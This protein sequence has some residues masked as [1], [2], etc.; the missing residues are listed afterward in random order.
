METGA[1]DTTEA[2]V[3]TNPVNDESAISGVPTEYFKET[4]RVDT[5]T[6]VDGDGIP[7]FVQETRRIETRDIDGDG[8]P[9]I[10]RITTTTTVIRGEGDSVQ[11]EENMEFS[12]RQW[13]SEARDSGMEPSDAG[14]K[15][16]MMNVEETEQ[17]VSEFVSEMED[18]S[19]PERNH[20]TAESPDLEL[21]DFGDKERKYSYGSEDHNNPSA[22]P[23]AVQQG[24]RDHEPF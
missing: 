2:D 4:T 15:V 11:D 22:S 1:E 17:N 21:S 10:T 13:E 19:S 5:K 14:I 6:D 3:E 9:D 16:A 8:I 7:D 20:S 18:P 24:N 23:G 12:P